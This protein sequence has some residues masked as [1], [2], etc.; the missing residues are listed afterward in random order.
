MSISPW[1]QWQVCGLPGHPGLPVVPTVFTTADASVTTPPHRMVG[2]IVAAMTSTQAT[3]QPACAEV[4]L[5]TLYNLF[6]IEISEQ[7]HMA[8][9]RS[10]G[11][12][13][14]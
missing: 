11:G 3:V 13:A 8:V 9:I 4:S 14:G 5:A 2:N 12:L 1:L 6:L 7:Q 10:L